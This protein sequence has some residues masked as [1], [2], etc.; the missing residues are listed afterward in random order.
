MSTSSIIPKLKELAGHLSQTFKRKPKSNSEM[1]DI[2]PRMPTVLCI[3]GC[4]VFAI[5]AFLIG[6][7]VLLGYLIYHPSLPSFRVEEAALDSLLL[8]AKFVLTSEIT[9]LL[10]VHNPNNKVTLNYES[11][12]FE[13]QFEKHTISTYILGAF[14]QVPKNT[15]ER[16]FVMSAQRVQLEANEGEDLSYSIQGNRVSYDFVGKVRTKAKFGHI[17]STKYWLHTTCQ[18]EF[19]PPPLGNGTLVNRHCHSRK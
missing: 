5:V 6:I 18:L 10:R 19:S 8:D 11:L 14:S 1:E 15:T 17:S 3:I 13:L 16:L 9:I 2:P 12:G 4:S 7:M